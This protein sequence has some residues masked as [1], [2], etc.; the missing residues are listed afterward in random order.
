[1]EMMSTRLG[2]IILL[3]DVLNRSVELARKKIIE[4]NPELDNIDAT[5]EIIGIGAVLFSDMSTRRHKDV[6]F[7]WKEVLNFDGESGPY[8]QYTHARLAALLRRYGNEIAAD[9]DYELLDSP[10]EY[11]VIDML[12]KFPKTVQD[13]AKQYDPFTIVSYLHLCKHQTDRNTCP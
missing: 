1:M 12:Y 4:K 9:A 8:L 3:D 2:N 10:E 11:R 6:S 7:D 5:A 13:A